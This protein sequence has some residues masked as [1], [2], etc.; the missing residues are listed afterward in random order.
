MFLGEVRARLHPEVLLINHGARNHVDGVLDWAHGMANSA[1][2]TVFFYDLRERVIAIELDGLISRVSTSEE[3]TSALE[4]V[5]II[6][7]RDQE[8]LL[9][10]FINGRNVLQLGSDHL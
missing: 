3:A 1:A 10:H 7:L 2:G 5:L 6:D 9:C 8:L 4:T